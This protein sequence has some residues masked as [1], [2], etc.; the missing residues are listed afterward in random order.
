MSPYRLALAHYRIQFPDLASLGTGDPPSAWKTEY[1][2]VAST[3][4][5]SLLLT[6]SAFEGGTGSGEKLFDQEVLLTALH[7]RRGE[8]DDDY[9]WRADDFRLRKTG[10]RATTY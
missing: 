8:L 5:S 4:F 10:I 6:H 1:D 7:D 3:A 9:D 2:R